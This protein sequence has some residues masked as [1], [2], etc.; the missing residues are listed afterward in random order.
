MVQK[1]RG[2]FPIKKPNRPSPVANVSKIG[3]L[4]R[5]ET[6]DY[7]N[8][9]LHDAVK[10]VAPII[11]EYNFKVGILSEMF[12]KK[13]NLLGLNVN[14]GQKILL[15]LRY[16]HNENEF[17][18][19]CDII[20]TFLH[21]LTHNFHGA[22]DKKFYDFLKELEDKYDK[23]RYGSS[24]NSGYRCEENK[25]GFGMLRAGIVDVRARRLAQFNKV[26]FKNESRALGS[27][28]KVTK[29]PL[30][31]RQARLEAAMR[32]L[33]DSKRCGSEFKESSEIPDD[34]ELEILE[35]RDKDQT[36]SDDNEKLEGNS[37]ES[38][39]GIDEEDIEILE[40]VDSKT[41]DRQEI[42]VID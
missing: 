13:A 19:M 4:M 20:G 10:A 6:R 37:R 42:I 14:K 18:P 1:G 17:L 34:D 21:E 15:R 32:R 11:H 24:G 30:D 38:S 36:Y 27:D 3:S 2:R 23:I 16:H 40:V 28:S 26:N 5:Y 33:E 41:R 31:A 35:I 8:Q 39:R 29:P 9:L 12:P 7:A 25:L 22:H